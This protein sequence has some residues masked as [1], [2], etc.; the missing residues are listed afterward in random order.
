MNRPR[1][2]TARQKEKEH[3]KK[4]MALLLCC[5]LCLCAAGAMA[6]EPV[7]LNIYENICYDIYP[8]G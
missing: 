7:T 6:A 8:N 4:W 3:M 5:L 2:R 1:S